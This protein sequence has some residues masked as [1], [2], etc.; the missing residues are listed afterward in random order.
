ME[1]RGIV[2]EGLR[3]LS[4]ILF[5]EVCHLCDG[6]LSPGERML[7]TRCA[8]RLPRTHY[9]RMP[10]NPMEDRFAGRIRFE[11]CTGYFLYTRD[12]GFARIVHDFKYRKFPSLALELGKIVGR[13]LFTTGFF[14]DAELIV[15]V[16]I[17]YLKRLRRGYNQAECFARGVAEMTGIPVACNLK[18]VRGHGT[19]TGKTAEEREENVRGIFRLKDVDSLRGKHIV[20][21]DDVCTTGSTLREAVETM[22]KATGG[23]CRFTLLTIGVTG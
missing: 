1:F 15:P 22:D 9:H 12:S 13:E 19:Q 3:S 2:E 23:D 16:P 21:V 18:A 4:A 14:G 7:C 20:V 10:T 17:H 5:P 11:R 8:D 6:P